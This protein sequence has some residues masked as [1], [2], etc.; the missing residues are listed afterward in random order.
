MR[1]DKKNEKEN[2]IIYITLKILDN[3]LQYSYTNNI[4]GRINIIFYSH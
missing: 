1:F 2:L 3:D 4:N